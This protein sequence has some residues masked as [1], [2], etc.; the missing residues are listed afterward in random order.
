MDDLKPVLYQANPRKI[1]TDED[2][3]TLRSLYEAGSTAEAL[4]T[5]FGV[6]V[7]TVYS[8]ASKGH[9]ATPRRILKAQTL[10]PSLSST[11]D[12]AA[13]VA[14]LWLERK[15]RARDVLYHGATKALDRFFA[16][17]PVPQSFAEAAT[18][19]KMLESAIN[20]DPARA[21]NTNIAFLINDSP[22]KLYDI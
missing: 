15:A 10:S 4:A 6:A 8:Y 12:P 7:G 17:A 2:K 5:R 14:A 1:L 11:N 19:S 16:T 9:W 22:P 13:A 21:S 3:G 18:A 20:P